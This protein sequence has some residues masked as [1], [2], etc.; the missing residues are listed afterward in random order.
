MGR[1][2][3]L[4]VLIAAASCARAPGA[5][6]PPASPGSFAPR[7]SRLDDRVVL[8]WVETETD[9]VPA[10]R[11]SVRTATG[12]TE[13]QTARRDPALASDAADVPSVV[14]LSSAGLAAAWTVKHGGSELARDLMASVSR[15]GGATWTPPS[16]PHRD[17][18]SSEHGMAAIVPDGGGGFGICWLDGRAGAHSEYGEGGTSL[19]WADWEGGAF[20]PDVLLDPRVCDCCKTSASRTDAG[21]VVAYR[22]RSD[23]NE[24]DI[25]LIRRVGGAWSSV[26]PVHGDGWTLSACPTN[27]P[28]VASSGSRTTVAW[29]TGANGAPSVWASRTPDG[30]RSPGAPTRIDAGNPVGRVDAAML[31]DGSTAVVWLE[32]RGGAA[33]VCVRRVAPDGSPAATVVVAAT[34]PSRASGYPSIVPAGGSDVLVAWTELGAARR[35]RARIA[36]LP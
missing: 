6:D 8:S 5:L 3:A 1:R 32:R 16:R 11:F 22:D 19:Y 25:S 9:G 27:G 23:A 35:V 24:R 14:P 15:D 12:W 26:V 30:G 34:S 10:L 31:P 33:D 36:T 17:D 13:P 28:A 7:L 4:V 29:F 2:A 20:G 18:S 21:P